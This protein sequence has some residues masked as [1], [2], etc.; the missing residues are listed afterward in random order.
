MAS[1]RFPNLP[2]N[3]LPKWLMDADLSQPIPIREVLEGSLYYPSSGRDGDP[4]RYLSGF[5]HSF[6]YVDYGVT[7]EGLLESLKDPKYSFKGYNLLGMREVCESELVPNGWTPIPPLPKDGNPKSGHRIEA[8]P[9]GIW[10]VFGREASLGPDHGPERFS[11]LFVGGDGV[12][13]FQALYIGNRCAP[14]VIA[15]I[16]PG[17]GFGGNW[18]NYEERDLLLGR[19]VMDYNLSSG[20]PQYLLFGGWNRE[21]TKPCWPEFGH[22]IAAWRVADGALTLWENDA[23][24]RL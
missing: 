19:S 22:Q 14:R 3:P 7:K 8:P 2:R 1:P 6:V 10:A 11:M 17:H 5:A 15:I 23:K 21:Y 9:F 4:V 16:Q 18:T 24:D 12:A 20:V 13:S